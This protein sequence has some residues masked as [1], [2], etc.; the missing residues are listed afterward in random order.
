MPAT[1]S[2]D[3]YEILG[4]IK[5]ATG[6]E[7]KKAY[8]RL[9]LQWHP[10]KNPE[11]KVEAEKKF[12]QIAEAYE[13]LSDAKK[14]DVY[15][16]Y[17][18]S[19]VLNEPSFDDDFRNMGRAGHFHF[20]FRSPEDVF[21]DFFGTDDPFGEFFLGFPSAGRTSFQSSFFDMDPFGGSGFTSFSSTNFGGP[22][23]GGNFKST[24][25]STKFVNGKKVTTRKVV[26]NGQE[27]VTVE[28]DGRITS[29]TVNGQ[30]LRDGGQKY[31]IKS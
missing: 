17:G 24:S 12:K 26:E 7:I 20:S 27:T 19:G 28:E 30:Q 2:E 11:K 29:R 8:R 10:D 21:K 15:D 4:V 6:Q 5:T 14:R 31:S 1:K 25:T 23:M 22:T 9:A 18:K 3:Y 16:R 13:V